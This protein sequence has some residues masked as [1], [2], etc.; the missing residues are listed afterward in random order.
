MIHLGRFANAARRAM[1]VAVVGAAPGM[2]L[3]AACVA[4]AHSLHVLVDGISPLVL[5]AAIGALL[6]NLG[7]VRPWARAGVDAAGRLVLRCGVVL[8]GFR[9]AVRDILDVGGGQLA[10]VVAVVVIT[11]LGTR[12]LGRK[13]GVGPDLSLLVAV[14]FAVCGASAVAAAAAVVGADED[15]VAFAVALVTLC[16]TLAIVLTPLIAPPLGLDGAE[17]GTWI[18]ASVHDVAQV[19]ATSAAAAPG[20]GQVL[21]AAI[22]VKLTRVAM[23]APLLALIAT[24]HG[25]GRSAPGVPVVPLFVVGFLGAVAIRSSGVLP[26]AWYDSLRVLEGWALAMGLFALGTAARIGRLRRL[27]GRP[28][29][30]GL[31]SWLLIAG[32]ALAAVVLE[33]T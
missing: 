1:A 17:L 30:L 12:Q 13:L 15:D 10:A 11:Y 31:L 14:G 22:V 16:G 2:A 29:A 18:G 8:L 23:L 4:A 27:G 33:H 6:G 28:I 9:I 5:S 19:I 24:R 32:V 25:A 21:H 26:L 7:A 20:D 3:A